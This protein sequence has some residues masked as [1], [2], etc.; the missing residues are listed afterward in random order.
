M[1]DPIADMLI[2]IKNAGD[3]KKESVVIP[4]SK[5]KSAILELL[6]KEGFVKSFSHSKCASHIGASG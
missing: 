6:E 2:R 4:Y 3:S 5:I 1:H